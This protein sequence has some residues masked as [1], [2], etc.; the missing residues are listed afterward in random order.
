MCT[1]QRAIRSCPAK[2]QICLN[3]IQRVHLFGLPVIV[4]PLLLS[5]EAFFRCRLHQSYSSNFSPSLTFSTVHFSPRYSWICLN[6]STPDSMFFLMQSTTS[7][8]PTTIYDPLLTGN[9]TDH[10]GWTRQQRNSIIGSNIVAN[11]WIQKKLTMKST[12]KS[13]GTLAANLQ[14]GA[15][16]APITDHP[17]NASPLIDRQ[18]PYAL[19]Q[20][21]EIPNT[22]EEAF[23]NFLLSRL[24]EVKAPQS[25]RKKIQRMIEHSRP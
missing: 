12:Q 25:L 1:I 10:C 23:R 6:K 3:S 22:E 2:I 14:V 19:S 5:A 21:V 17:S 20:S 16:R 13:N 11:R 24:P 4:N 9:P 8:R 15:S 18:K 7:N